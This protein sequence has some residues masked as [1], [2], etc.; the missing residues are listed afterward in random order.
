MLTDSEVC[1]QVDGRFPGIRQPLPEPYALGSG[2]PEP[3]LAGARAAAHLGARG[4]RALLREH[5]DAA[6]PAAHA[7]GEVP[8]ETSDIFAA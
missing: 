5:D 8:G 2:A 7:G 4:R 6:H 1:D 3:P